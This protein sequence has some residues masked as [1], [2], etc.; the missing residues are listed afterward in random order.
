[1]G[2]KPAYVRE[3][4]PLERDDEKTGELAKLVKEVVAL[5]DRKEHLEGELK[6]L[7]HDISEREALAQSVMDDAGIDEFKT[8]EGQ[9]KKRQFING[10]I[11]DDSKFYAELLKRGE[12]G[13]VQVALGGEMLETYREWYERKYKQK[14]TNI[15]LS[16]HHKRLES[17]LRERG[18]E[19]PSG[20]EVTRHIKVDIRRRK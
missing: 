11:V 2:K 18:D 20:V 14:L 8:A 19:T 17:Y 9:A 7:S 4:V 16:V 5:Q 3:E 6:Q 10:R 15:K 13:L 1:M 12:A